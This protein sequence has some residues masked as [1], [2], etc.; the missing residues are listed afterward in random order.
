MARRTPATAPTSPSKGNRRPRYRL[1]RHSERRYVRLLRHRSRAA[2]GA[3]FECQSWRRISR[4]PTRTA[5]VEGWVIKP[6]LRMSSN[7][8]ADLGGSRRWYCV[9]S[10]AA[11]DNRATTRNSSSDAGRRGITDL[12]QDVTPTAQRLVWLRDKRCSA[13]SSESPK[14][15][16]AR[17]S[18]RLVRGACLPGRGPFGDRALVR[19]IVGYLTARKRSLPRLGEEHL[20]RVVPVVKLVNADFDL[21]LRSRAR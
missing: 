11:Q 16:T 3:M 10:R 13:P 7:R 1:V 20:N 17:D 4:S 14:T 12:A 21:R 15:T 2:E 6:A 8:R 5:R 9:S 18:L 19:R